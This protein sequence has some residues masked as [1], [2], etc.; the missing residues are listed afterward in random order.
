MVLSPLRSLFGSPIMIVAEIP[1]AGAKTTQQKTQ[2]NA[3]RLAPVCTA[4][5]ASPC[6]S[7][8]S[9]DRPSG[10]LKVSVLAHSVQVWVPFFK[11]AVHQQITC[12]FQARGYRGRNAR[13][14]PL[15]AGVLFC[16]KGASLNDWGAG[17]RERRFYYASE[18]PR[19]GT[20]MPTQA[21]RE[22]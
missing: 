16:T 22:L 1:P 11:S 14:P 2:Q 7:Q 4:H 12:R 5:C 21:H 10:G 13:A 3:L 8:G 20:Q 9:V 15:K 19:S 6:K 17:A 18:S